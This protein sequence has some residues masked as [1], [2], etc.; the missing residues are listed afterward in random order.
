MGVGESRHGDE[1]SL[2]LKLRPSG[3]TES[4]LLD[5][6]VTPAESEDLRDCLTTAGLHISDVVELS[7]GDTLQIFSTVVAAAG[8]FGA[9]SAAVVAFLHRHR[10]REA[11]LTVAG[12]PVVLKDYSRRDIEKIA[13]MLRKADAEHR[14]AWRQELDRSRGSGDEPSANDRL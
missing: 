12:E 7:A 9:L 11:H 5:L 3:T 10:G 6:R 14:R 8:G 4:G 13:A 2:V 1:T